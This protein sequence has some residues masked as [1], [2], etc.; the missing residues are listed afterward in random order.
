MTEVARDFVI[1]THNWKTEL[2][3]SLQN[4]SPFLAVAL[5]PA[6][7]VEL[8]SVTQSCTCCFNQEHSCQFIQKNGIAEG[9]LQN[10]VWSRN[11]GSSKP[12]LKQQQQAGQSWRCGL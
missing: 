10:S 1:N 5:G 4:L 7:V 11:T 12:P 9:H 6:V 8:C 3:G 2:Q